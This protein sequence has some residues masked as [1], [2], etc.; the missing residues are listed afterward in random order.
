MS[1]YSKIF[2][3]VPVEIPNKSGFD[4]SHENVFTAK[5]GTLIPSMV[6]LLLPNDTVSLGTKLQVQL[7]PMATDFYGSVNAKCE[8]FFVPLRVLYGGMQEI[9]THPTNGAV[10]PVGT[11][12][13]QKARFVPHLSVP[14][15]LIGPGTLCDYLG[16]KVASNVGQQSVE[17]SVLPF[18]MYHKVYDDWYRD[19]RIQKPVFSK[20]QS[21]GNYNQDFDFLPYVTVFGNPTP[22]VLSGSYCSDGVRATDL[23]QRN[24]SKDYFTNATTLP[25]AGQGADV[26]FV[27]NT[28]SGQTAGT[29][30]FSISTLRAANALQQWLERNNLAGY[31]YGDQIKA[32]FGIYPADAITDRSIY[33][34]SMTVPVYNKSVYTNTGSTATQNPF[35]STGAKYASPVGVGD[36][37]LVD[38]FTASEHGFLL[39][40]FSLVPDKLYATG[41][42]KYLFYDRQSDFPEP[43]L[44]STGDEPIFDW[45][46]TQNIPSASP[47]TFGYTQRYSSHK[48]MPDEVHGLLRDGESLASFALQS[49]Y[50]ST[51]GINS[52]FLQIPTNY[53]DGVTAVSADVSTYGCWVD[54]YFVYKKSSTLPAYSIPTLGDM[55][56]THTEIIDNGGKRL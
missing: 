28:P 33:L 46:L 2:H 40:M 34:G 47:S 6:D 56:D 45:E 11:G 22:T 8:C 3:K 7:P 50:A 15:N 38:K 21:G 51:S 10:Y 52:S 43:I 19:S 36:K 49:S 12:S 13:N 29:G 5:C 1:N 53:M 54:Q 35:T 37:S 26:T 55:K 44:A 23:R 4:C 9:L 48:F 42:R 24:W 39:V 25:Q 18:L 31:R 41:S 32:R 20:P 16:S 17:Y 14:D 30:S 27:T